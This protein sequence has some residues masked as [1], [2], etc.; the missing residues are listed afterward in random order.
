M[1]T[2]YTIPA[3][4][5]CETTKSFLKKAEIEHRIIDVSKD[6]EAYNFIKGLGYTQ[7]PVVVFEDRHWSGFR[8]DELNALKAHFA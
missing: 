5:Q 6:A 4:P 3:C 8:F 7:A 1:V 2:V